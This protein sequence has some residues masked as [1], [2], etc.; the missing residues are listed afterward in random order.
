MLDMLRRALPSPVDDRGEHGV[1]RG[2]P[3]LSARDPQRFR[4]MVASAAITPTSPVPLVDKRS[5][6]QLHSTLDHHDIMRQQ[7]TDMAWTAP[8]TQL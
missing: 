1:A 7:R 5:R 6:W 3:L 2:A 8:T 4:A